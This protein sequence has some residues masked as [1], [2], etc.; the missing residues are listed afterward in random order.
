MA[1]QIVI[2]YKGSPLTYHVTVEEEDVFL[3]RLQNGQQNHL[4]YVP[5]KLVIRKKGKI[6]I[7]DLE[8]YNELVSSLT[9]EILEINFNHKISA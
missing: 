9:K 6:W 5:E 8:D 3:F 4:T 7:S 2:H 1:L